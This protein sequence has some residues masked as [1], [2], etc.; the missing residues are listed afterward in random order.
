MEHMTS[1]RG[2]ASL[3]F[4][5]Y[6]SMITIYILIVIGGYVVFSGSGAACGSS[7]PDSWPLCNGQ[8]IPNPSSPN[9]AQALVEWTH[10][11]FTLVAGLFV[12]G[13]T[14]VAWSRYR[15]EKRILQFSTASFLVLIGQ[16][17]LGMVTVKTD[18]DPLV[19]TAH[20]A[21]ASALFAT[22]ILNAITVRGLNV[23][24]PKDL[25]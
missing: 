11:L 6:G 20:L 9:Y 19:S 18:L 8:F 21:V 2:Y 15:E 1:L 17:L 3:R 24:S 10:R 7:N 5:A 13:S 12:F 16:I 25:R 14:I 22:V 4:L 23:S